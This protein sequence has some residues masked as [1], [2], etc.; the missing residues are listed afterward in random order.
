MLSSLSESMKQL[1][2]TVSHIQGSMLT[3]EERYNQR[4]CKIEAFLE[5]VVA[6][7]VGPRALS[8]PSTASA[9]QNVSVPHRTNSATQLQQPQDGCAN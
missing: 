4:F 6:P 7:T 3:M 5:N 9:A 1:S 8:L 2:E